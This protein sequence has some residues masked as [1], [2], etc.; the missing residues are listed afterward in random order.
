MSSCISSS[1]HHCAR[2]LPAPTA[3]VHLAAANSC[4]S[5]YHRRVGSLRAMRAKAPSS[6]AP[7]WDRKAA[8]VQ[9]EMVEEAAMSC[10]MHG[11]V[12]DDRGNPGRSQELGREIWKAK[13]QLRITMMLSVSA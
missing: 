4:V 2:R 1:Y 9:A 7:V 10:A 6:A 13:K 8:A 3:R 11:L 12:V 5:P